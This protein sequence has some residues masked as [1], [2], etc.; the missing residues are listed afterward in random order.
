MPLN[1]DLSISQQNDNENN[2][3]YCQIETTKPKIKINQF[4][5]KFIL[6]VDKIYQRI[7]SENKRVSIGTIRW[8]GRYISGVCTP[9]FKNMSLINYQKKVMNYKKNFFFNNFQV[10]TLGPT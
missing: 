1:L 4:N 3:E 2:N 5:K 7:L 6:I 8:R 10:N 9:L